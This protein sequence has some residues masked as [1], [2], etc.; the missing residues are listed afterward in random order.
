MLFVYYMISFFFTLEDKKSSQTS[1]YWFIAFSPMIF[2]IGFAMFVL[3][4]FLQVEKGLAQYINNI[5]AWSGWSSFEKLTPC[6]LAV[7]PAVMGFTTF[8]TQNN[9]YFDLETILVYLLGNLLVTYVM[10]M[11]VCAGL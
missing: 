5:F 8:S 1:A 11:L 2:L 7:G 6:L 10:A 9:I 4:S 3:P